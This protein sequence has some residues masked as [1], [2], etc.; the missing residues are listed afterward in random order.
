MLIREFRILET[1]FISRLLPIYRDPSG[2]RQVKRIGLQ[3]I[4]PL[5]KGDLPM[6]CRKSTTQELSEIPIRAEP[7]GSNFRWLI[8][9]LFERGVYEGGA[10]IV[11]EFSTARHSQ[12]LWMSP[13]ILNVSWESPCVTLGH[14]LCDWQ[15]NWVP[16]I[17]SR[18]WWSHWNWFS[19]GLKSSPCSDRP[20]M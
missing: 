16:G 13:A 1:E 17:N 6:Q 10:C 14:E 19:D 9:D 2:C 5:W 11:L 8:S 12:G 7:H 15:K 4:N 3:D 18:L 20:S